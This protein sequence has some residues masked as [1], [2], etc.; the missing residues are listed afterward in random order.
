MEENS[1]EITLHSLPAHSGR[2]F[3]RNLSFHCS[4]SDLKKL[5]EENCF[6]ISEAKAF[7][8]SPNNRNPSRKPMYYGYVELCDPTEIELAMSTLNGKLFM[9]RCLSVQRYMPYQD[10]HHHHYSNENISPNEGQPD[11]LGGERYS[12]HFPDSEF[13][14][15]AYQLHVSFKAQTL[16]K[17]KLNEENLR[18]LFQTY[19]NI[20]DVI[21]KK[22]VYDAERKL[23]GYAFIQFERDE[24]AHEAICAMH[25]RIV[26]N[27]HYNCRRSKKHAI[28]S[29][30]FDT[31]VASET[32]SLSMHYHGPSSHNNFHHAASSYIAPPMTPMGS[33]HNQVPGNMM[34]S[35]P[36]NGMN[37]SMMM[38]PRSYSG[39]EQQYMMAM[40]TNAGM[41]PAPSMDGFAYCPLGVASTGIAESV[42]SDDAYSTKNSTHDSMNNQSCNQQ[43]LRSQFPGYMP[44]TAMM[45]PPFYGQPSY[46]PIMPTG[47]QSIPFLPPPLIPP[48]LPLPRMPP[49]G[50]TMA[51]AGFNTHLSPAAADARSN[52]PRSTVSTTSSAAS[53]THNDAH[54]G[55]G[56]D[57]ENSPSQQ[58]LHH[59]S[60]PS[61]PHSSGDF[62]RQQVQ[63]SMSAPQPYPTGRGSYFDAGMVPQQQQTRLFSPLPASAASAVAFVPRSHT[64]YNNF[65]HNNSMPSQPQQQQRQ[66]VNNHYGQYYV[67]Q[68]PSPPQQ[69]YQQGQDNVGN[70]PQPSSVH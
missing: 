17:R 68:Q 56:T 59:P 40:M 67:M 30:S 41:M 10:H 35:S 48:P 63:H 44:P 37:A 34:Y 26:D 58:F 64:N 9:G 42:S 55:G 14:D 53:A 22:H 1:Q 54:H 11:E 51:P 36:S 49:A 31:T 39:D 52:P 46:F 15:R 29:C 28:R 50:N 43:A 21:I 3:I 65:Q 32:P 70:Y 13:G 7:T 60:F 69:T 2:I 8:S 24:S 23:G 12:D 33:F 57:T 45:P 38:V 62:H 47:P 61:E 18:N 27:I 6:A 4:D 66:Q 20:L 25:N 5:L 16:G 19:G